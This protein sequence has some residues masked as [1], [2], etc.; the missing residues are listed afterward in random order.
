MS[1]VIAWTNDVEVEF[2][3][4]ASSFITVAQSA[5]HILNQEGQGVNLADMGKTWH[6]TVI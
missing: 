1:K 3:S 4:S 2:K 6:I 5:V